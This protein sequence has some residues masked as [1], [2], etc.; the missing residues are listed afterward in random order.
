MSDRSRTNGAQFAVLLV[1][2]MVLAGM[3]W[4]IL[5][6]LK[7]DSG[8]AAPAPTETPAGTATPT[9]TP[10]PSATATATFTPTPLPSLTPTPTPLVPLA[11]IPPDAPR[12]LAQVVAVINGAYL[13]VRT[14]SERFF[15]RYLGVD[16]TGDGQAAAALN[17]AL[18]E[19]Q[20]VTLVTDGAESDGQGNQLRYVLAGDKFVN[21]ELV[22]QGTALAG[23]YPPAVQCIDTLLAAELLAHTE[24]LGYWASTGVEPLVTIPANPA[25]VCDC[26]VRYACSEFSSQSD[27]QD[28]YNACGDY[29]NSSLDPDHNGLACDE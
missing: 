12:E 27:A 21:F 19:G 23:L 24:N 28:C 29:R 11:C 9:S 10:S 15:V 3:I 7:P 8:V 22:R 1:G 18:V 13:E 2:V 5:F 16:P 20:E 14:G 17:Q 4:L 6:L 25:P 26:R